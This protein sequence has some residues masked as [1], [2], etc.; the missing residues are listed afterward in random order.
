MSAPTLKPT[1]D[2]STEVV[3]PRLNVAASYGY[4]SV[5]SKSLTMSCCTLKKDGPAKITAWMRSV[6][7]NVA[8]AC[9]CTASSSRATPATSPSTVRGRLK[10]NG[11]GT[12]ALNAVGVLLEKRVTPTPTPM[13]R[14]SPAPTEMLNAGPD[15]TS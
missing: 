3:M 5:T 4:V 2:S 12:D 7:T 8:R 13:L 6:G 14:Q 1:F 10:K 11:C 9:T 15:L